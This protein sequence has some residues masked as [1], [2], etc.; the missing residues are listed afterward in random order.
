MLSRGQYSSI[1]EDEEAGTVP[2]TFERARRTFKPIAALLIATT[3]VAAAISTAPHNDA[4][5]STAS[6]EQHLAAPELADP[7]LTLSYQNATT[8]SAD[9]DGIPVVTITYGTC[10]IPIEAYCYDQ[11]NEKSCQPKDVTAFVSNE[12]EMG[13]MD[14]VWSDD[15]DCVKDAVNVV[16]WS[17][18]TDDLG[19]MELSITT[20]MKFYNPTIS[21]VLLS[22][23]RLLDNTYT[24]SRSSD[25]VADNNDF[26]FQCAPAPTSAPTTP[27]AAPSA[28]PVPAPSAKP[29]TVPT[30]EPTE[31]P[32]PAPTSAPTAKPTGVPVPTPTA[33]PTGVPV[34]T[35]TAKPTGVP[36]PAPTAKPTSV[37]TAKP[38]EIP[39]PSPTTKP[40]FVPTA[41]PTGIP[42]PAPTAKPT[43]VPTAKPTPQPSL[44]DPTYSVSYSGGDS[45]SGTEQPLVT[46][47]YGLC[48]VKLAAICYDSSDGSDCQPYS[49]SVVAASY[50]TVDWDDSL[51]SST[52]CDTDL[53]VKTSWSVST[54]GSSMTITVINDET[55][56]DAGHKIYAGYEIGGS[57]YTVTENGYSSNTFS[58]SC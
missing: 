16:K 23:Y 38:T 17:I 36:V 5:S 55:D 1:P 11:T 37:P 49:V 50:M 51:S 24:V 21:N 57:Q 42:V 4:A 40:T 34:P 25:G 48:S 9:V 52:D 26:F 6:S 22:G 12:N 53:E 10:T 15:S 7:V 44:D 29:T 18:V 8:C 28:A 41:K 58:Y 14:L 32:V 56:Y 2:D 45:C 31:V 54:S 27:S 19:A 30:P 13:K 35:P 43:F 3:L 20:H 46:I 47:S 33:K 39:I